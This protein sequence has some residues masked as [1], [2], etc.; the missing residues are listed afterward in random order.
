[1]SL[2]EILSVANIQKKEEV[3][4]TEELLLQNIDRYRD[5]IAYWRVYPDRLIDYY[6]SLNPD[7][8]F[9]LYGYQRLFLRAVM[10][11]QYVYATFVRAWS[12]SFMSVMAMM[13]RAILYPGVKLFT[14]AGAKEQSAS[15]LSAKVNEIC[16][17]IPAMAKE[18]IWDTR[19]TR[20]KT[21]QTKDTVIYTF[22]N[23]SILQNVVANQN[24]RGGRFQAG[25]MEEVITIDQDILNEVILPLMNVNRKI[26]YNNK[27]VEDPDEKVNKSATYITTAGYKGSFSYEKLIET[28]IV[29][30]ARPKKAIVLG[31]SWRVPVVE[32][33]LSKDFVR[34]LKLDG[35]FNEASF[36]R[37]Y[38]SKWAGDVES[39]FFNSAAFEKHR[40]I[41]V[42]E[43]RYSNK[44]GKDGYY[45]LGVDVGRYGDQTEIVVIKVSKLNSGNLLKQLVN[46]YTLEGEN[47]I[48]QARKIKKIFRDYKCKAA[49]VDGN[50]VGAGLVDLLVVDDT[51]PETDEFLPGWGV[52]NDEEDPKTGRTKYKS[53]ET[54]NTI[55]N[56]MYIMKATAALNSEMYA[57]CKNQI[58]NGRVRF[59]ISET[60]AK[61]KLLSQ[62]QGQKMSHAKRA[63]YLFPYTQTSI[64]ES[65]MCN[66][67]EESDGANLIVKQSSKKIKK[68]KVSA[69]IYGLYYC[70]ME[71]DRRGKR[72]KF[73][74]ADLMLFSGSLKV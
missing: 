23:G 26:P 25:L 7:N 53:L 72:K 32:G 59:L 57:Y 73:N 28:L 1:M 68:D 10:R 31:G 43:Y 13:L 34:D 38:E 6:C 29:S 22:K 35:T 69:L 62:S 8:V 45:I 50:G 12:K 21:S 54:E 64:L 56:A 70:K 55:H 49:V 65:Q 15:I 67:I 11:H 39:A 36:D 44:I 42:A 58:N 60:I 19:G 63:E 30:I 46:I 47:F 61:N 48:L 33:L 24:T 51:D 17:L 71:E 14:V 20:Q 9:H 52:I 5:L 37:E 74:A 40:V 66:L 27:L 3:E 2:K 4:I 41:N 18:I 16:T